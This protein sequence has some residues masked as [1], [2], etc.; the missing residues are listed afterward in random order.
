MRK[1]FKKYFNGGDM[2]LPQEGASNAQ[3]AGQFAYLQGL[4]NTGQGMVQDWGDNYLSDKGFDQGEIDIVNKK[5]GRN[6]A[7]IPGVGM[8]ASMG[9]G[10]FNAVTGRT[11]DALADYRLNKQKGE[12]QRAN[13][14][15]DYSGYAQDAQVTFAQGGDISMLEGPSHAEGGI[16]LTNNAEVEGGEVKADDFILSD[17]LGDKNGTFAEQM[18]KEIKKGSPLRDSQNDTYSKFR[19]MNKKNELVDLN[20][21]AI[22]DMQNI[23]MSEASGE[24]PKAMAAMGGYLKRKKMMYNGGNMPGTDNDPMSKYENLY[25]QKMEKLMTFSPNA[26]DLGADI[27]ADLYGPQDSPYYM[28]DRSM[29]DLMKVFGKAGAYYYQIVRGDDRRLVNPVRHRKSIGTE[30]T[31]SEDCSDIHFLEL[32]LETLCE[33]LFRFMDIDDNFG[34]TITIK[35]KHFNFVLE[36]KSK[37]FTTELN[38]YQLLPDFATLFQ[39]IFYY[40]EY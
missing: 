2:F 4:Q 31:F 30:K 23:I 20:K 36:T 14:F 16:Q 28:E 22:A 10:A 25:N 38:D 13:D 34:K 39:V 26:T 35:I 27:P 19:I 8:W 32:T 9:V 37:T 40:I 15:N 29:Q 24:S 18:K 11:K 5:G 1:R 17:R 7:K 33:K 3:A 12:T 6:L 21:A